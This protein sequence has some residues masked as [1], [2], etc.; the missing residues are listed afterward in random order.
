[1]RYDSLE[2]VAISGWPVP[3][4]S[5][6]ACTRFEANPFEAGMNL[7]AAGSVFPVVPDV[8]RQITVGEHLRLSRH[9]SY[10]HCEDQ[11]QQQQ[12]HRWHNETKQPIN[13]C[14]RRIGRIGRVSRNKAKA[15]VA[16]RVEA[17]DLPDLKC[18]AASRCSLGSPLR[19]SFSR[20]NIPT[21]SEIEL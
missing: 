5:M 9:T 1:M 17:H 14:C 8:E 18:H 19:D 20:A 10:C 15:R 2:A 12:R 16:P 3:V 11:Y 13:G 21:G 4:G 6:C 7:D